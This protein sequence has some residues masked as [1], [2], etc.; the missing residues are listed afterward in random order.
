MRTLIHAAFGAALLAGSTIAM[1]GEIKGPP[2]GSNLPDAPRL[3]NGAS[4]CSF[5]GLNDTPEGQGMPGQPEYDPGGIAQSYG[6][7]H[8]QGLFDPSDPAQ[9]DQFAFPGTGCNPTRSFPIPG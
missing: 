7:F 4:W 3:S 8:S 9:R 2:P 6:Y 1:A 5:S